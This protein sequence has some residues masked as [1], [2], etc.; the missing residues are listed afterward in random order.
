MH[1]SRLA[2]SI[3]VL[4]SA[5]GACG[6]SSL[7]AIF[8]ANNGNLEGSVTSFLVDDSGVLAFVQKL[9]LGSVPAGQQYDPGT[10]ATCISI[11][12]DG[13][14]LALGHATSSQTVERISVVEVHADASLSLAMTFDTPDSPI[15]LQWLD[16]E[17]LAVTRTSLQ[18]FNQ[19]L[20]YDVDPEAGTA[21]QVD[22]EP[23][24]SFSSAL[25]LHPSGQWLYA[26]DSIGTSLTVLAV[27][28]GG[29]L[30]PVQTL[31][32]AGYPL[33]PGVSPDGAWL[34][35]G[36]GISVGGKAVLGFAIDAATGTV[37]ALPD[38]PF[39]SP[40]ASPKQVVYSSDSTLAFVAHG[41][42]ATIRG[43]A[44]DARTGSLTDLGTLFDVGFQG[45]LGEIAVAGSFLFAADRDTLIDGVRGVHS[46]TIAPDGTLVSNG[47]ITDTQGS[48]PNAIATWFPAAPPF[49]DIDGDGV[50]DGADLGA[51]LAAWGGSDPAADLDDD[52]VVNG[53]DLGLLLGAWS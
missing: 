3:L 22:A 31:T 11:S 18:S 44:V 5:A 29:A 36:G 27:G 24:G 4:S 47:P 14:W 35:A 26:Q 46:L 34:G 37:S 13:R 16:A 2:A 38:S 15:D 43:F 12:P 19:V 33:G 40:G 39:T 32:T 17:H 23:T 10:N 42:D 20:V 53:A 51:L 28:A 7:P 6:Q 41:A 25:A 30:T 8:V 9:V 21:E 45:S 52:G 48:T 1:P 49:G 50:V